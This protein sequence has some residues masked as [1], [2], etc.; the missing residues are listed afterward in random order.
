MPVRRPMVPFDAGLAGRAVAAA[1]WIEAGA[2][3][4]DAALVVALVDAALLDVALVD[5]ALFGV[6]DSAPLG[7][8]FVESREE[9]TAIDRRSNESSPNR[10]LKASRM[11]H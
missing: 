9:D 4:V 8:E 10:I 5:A 3:R 7:T 11:A 1:P 2:F 6:P